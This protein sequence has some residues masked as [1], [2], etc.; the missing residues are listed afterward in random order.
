MKS[1]LELKLA[2]LLLVTVT[3]GAV[4]GA[5]LY[6]Y[7]YSGGHWLAVIIS[8]AIAV[9]AA[10][11]GA[12]IALRPVRVLLR[13]MHRLVASYRDGD[14]NQSLAV[15]RDDQLGALME[16]HNQL[17]RT[18]REERSNLVQRERLLDTVT[19]HSPVALVL[20]DAHRQVV[21]AN[22]A[23]GG[24][25][26]AGR[27]FVGHDFTTVL[28]R[29][30]EPIRLAAEARGDSL[31]SAEM[32]GIQETFHLSQ[33]E[34][35]LQ[36]R[37]HRLYLLKTVTREISR[38]EVTTWKNLIR[39]LSHELN[40]SLAPIA[41][42]AH[43]GAKLN[44]RGRTEELAAVFATIRERAMHLHQFISRYAAFAKL[45][46]PR[47]GPVEWSVLVDL[48]AR[49]QTF[50]V[51]SALPSR[52]GWFD[53]P[54]VEQA[55]INLLKNAHES[56]GPAKQVELAISCREN[57]QR[58]EVRDRGTGM[59]KLVLAQALL[60]FYST[61]RDGTGIGLALAREICEAHGGRIS[62]A[63]REGGGLC[64]ALILPIPGATTES[65]QPDEAHAD[66]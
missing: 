14:F 12:R 11:W 16:A 61:K 55:L 5:A 48:L 39:V 7:S 64:V 24:L 35:H 40:N 65:E 58:L 25:L 62:I 23:A 34:F 42:L 63:N 45:P 9:A 6:R 1:G 2:A 26:N 36:G 32:A 13:A 53:C 66:C 44:E 59:S 33:R 30:P 46:A 29:A 17:G 28:G 8:A 38:Q 56:N 19:R 47:P 22:L 3:L 31:F 10:I 52:P 60:P 51:P 20:V 27:G 57:E 4:A 54:Q 41:S 50:L 18:L 49:E 37:A 43:S 21:Y 15:D